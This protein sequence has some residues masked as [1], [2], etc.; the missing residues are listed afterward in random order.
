M[1]GLHATVRFRRRLNEAAIRESAIKRDIG[2]KDTSALIPGHGGLLDR[3][4]SLTF[5]AP[6]FFHIHAYFALSHF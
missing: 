1:V 2:V 4:D 6:L 5:T 3:A